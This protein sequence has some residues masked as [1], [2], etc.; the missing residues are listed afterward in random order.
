[1]GELQ[2]V[3]SSKADKD[4]DGRKLPDVPDAGDAM[5]GQSATEVKNRVRQVW[6]AYTPDGTELVL[7][8]RELEGYRYAADNGM[9]CKPVAF[10]QSVMQQIGQQQ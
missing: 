9:R 4:A 10:G 6:C 1:M 7:F 8:G 3:R 5:P 2:G